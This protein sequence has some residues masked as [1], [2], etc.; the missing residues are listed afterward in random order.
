MESRKLS[1][2]SRFGIV[3][4]WHQRSAR[5]ETQLHH[6]CD[7]CF[8]DSSSKNDAIATSLS[9]PKGEDQVRDEF[10]KYPGRSVVTV[11][12]FAPRCSVEQKTSTPLSCYPV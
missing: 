7:D 3:T 6:F 2:S 9:R 12:L 1:I 8:P 11:S 10:G 4:V 5:P